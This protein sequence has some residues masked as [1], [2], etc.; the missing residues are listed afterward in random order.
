MQKVEQAALLRIGVQMDKPRDSAQ[1]ASITA[2]SRVSRS[3]QW[4][5][6]DIVDEPLPPKITRLLARL[7]RLE[8]RAAGKRAFTPI[9]ALPM[10]CDK[11]SAPPTAQAN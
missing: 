11:H 8:A 1:M 9:V 2:L 7:E 10:L 5:S 6:R 3:L 4:N